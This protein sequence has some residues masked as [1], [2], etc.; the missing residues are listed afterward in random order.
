MHSKFIKMVDLMLSF[1]NT[2]T[3]TIKVTQGKWEIVDVWHLHF[4]ACGD[5]IT[6]TCLCL[7]SLNYTH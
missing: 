3:H 2:H 7:N 5:D 6:G 4:P 1:L